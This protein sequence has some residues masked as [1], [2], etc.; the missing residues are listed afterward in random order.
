[1]PGSTVD[2]VNNY[3]YG[4]VT[5]FSIFAPLG[6]IPT[7]SPVVTPSGIAGVGVG[8]VEYECTDDLTYRFDEVGPEGPSKQIPSGYCYD[9]K[10]NNIRLTETM[11]GIEVI[12][13]WTDPFDIPS[14]LAYDYYEV[15]VLQYSSQYPDVRKEVSVDKITSVDFNVK[16]SKA[17]I[18]KYAIDEDTIKMLRYSN[19]NYEEAELSKLSEDSDY[20]TYRIS[21]TSG[22][23]VITGEKIGIHVIFD[24][25]N[26]YYAGLPVDFL[27]L[28]DLIAAYYRE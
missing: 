28:I 14:G 6:V 8:T 12:V 20:I 1:V 23:Y 10:L 26:D 3:I 22:K 7:P 17:W 5:D 21:G 13:D 11:Y 24:V 9:V 16:V 4:N 15:R 27:D 18:K 25:I 19:G 2:S